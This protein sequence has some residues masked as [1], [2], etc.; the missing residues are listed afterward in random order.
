M[1][2][3]IAVSTRIDAPPSRVWRALTDPE[4]IKSYFFGADVKT[5]WR[6]GSAITWEGEY[7]GK[8]FKDK[9]K[10]VSADHEKRLE[11]THWSPLSG[12]ED[13]PENYHTIIWKIAAREEGS[14]VTLTQRN[15][16]GV[17]P[18]DAR[19]S[20]QPVIEG[21]KRVLEK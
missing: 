4:I 8:A 10:V 1:T 14:E 18:A 11:V 7:D 19:K 12:L 20:W 21:L 2:D 15:L 17:K 6:P 5:D 16:T 9:G 3:Q 13:K